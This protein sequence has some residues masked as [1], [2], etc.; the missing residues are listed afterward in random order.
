ME[1]Q[2]NDA[3]TSNKTNDTND[4]GVMEEESST[5][6][7]NIITS[8]D[9]GSNPTKEKETTS[10]MNT[11]NIFPKS[12]NTTLGIEQAILAIKNFDSFNKSTEQ[13]NNNTIEIIEMPKSDTEHYTC[14]CI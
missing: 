10:N 2:S 11:D 6:S 4:P 14:Q 9:V 1:Q 13:P 7:F 3:C 12:E 8:L 5:T